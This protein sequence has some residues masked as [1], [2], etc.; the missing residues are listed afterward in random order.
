[1]EPKTRILIVEDDMIIAANISLQ[2]SNLG[3]EVIGIQ[4]RGEEAVATAKANPPDLIL[5]DINLKGHL[6]GIETARAI[7]QNQNIPII[8]LTANTD[9][10]TFLKAKETHPYAFISKPFNKL[11]LQRTIALTVEQVKDSAETNGKTQ[12]NLQVMHDRIFVRHK[13][14]MVKLMLRDIF[15][16][17]AE[18]NYCNIVTNHGCHLVVGTLKT[19]E[20]ELPRAHFVRVHRSYVINISNVDVLADNH[21]EINKKAI[22]VSKSFKENLLARLHT[23]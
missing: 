7:Q 14:K 12:P 19:I 9:D 1:M 21:I 18:R 10:S 15:Y 17:E 2:L 13:G 6:N 16:I 8:Y 4:S 5:M 3:Y 23:I 11:D 20:K 22:P